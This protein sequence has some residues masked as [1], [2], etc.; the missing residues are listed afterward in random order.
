MTDSIYQEVILDHYRNPRNQGSLDCPTHQADGLNASCGDKLHM[1]I[2]IQDGTIK[3]IRF[4]GVGCAISQ[5]SASLLTETVQGKKA[6]EA[7]ALT[8]TD[9][10][11]LLGI[12]LSPSRVKCALLSLETLK[13]AINHKSH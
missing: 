4:R 8:P 9:L 2:Q 11:A 10:L 6:T 7:Q 12:A 5:A 1:D 3:S 13:Q